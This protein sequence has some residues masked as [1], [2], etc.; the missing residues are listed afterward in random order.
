[1]AIFNMGVHMLPTDTGTYD[2]GSSSNHWD[3]LYVDKINGTSVSGLTT[4]HRFSATIPTTGWTQ[5]DGI[6]HVTVSVSGVLASDQGG[7]VG[8]VQSGTESTDS[9]IRS[10]WNKI[11]RMT[12][13]N[14]GIVVYATEVPAVAVPFLMEVFR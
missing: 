1:M 4:V 13:A 6:Y 2:L 5:A 11:V 9:A 7:G 3:D 12:T 8:P 10:A 14:D